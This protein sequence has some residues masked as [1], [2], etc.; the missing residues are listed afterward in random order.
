MN[1][2]KFDGREKP[3]M[4]TQGSVKPVL[5][6]RIL[7]HQA[8]VLKWASETGTSFIEDIVKCDDCPEYNWHNTALTR[9]QGHSPQP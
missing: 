8:L 5:P 2:H 9:S 3:I 4:P 7:F 6:L 1:I